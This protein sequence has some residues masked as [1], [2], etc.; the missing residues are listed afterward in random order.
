MLDEAERQAPELA[1]VQQYRSNVAFL[2]GDRQ[3]AISALER[4][5]ELEPDRVLLS[6]N[7]KRLRAEPPAAEH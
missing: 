1:L 6:E 4:G 3:A 5:L 7:L 2:M